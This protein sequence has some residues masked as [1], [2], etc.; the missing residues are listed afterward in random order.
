[1][2]GEL[3][4]LKWNNHKSTF[5]QVIKSLRNERESPFA[6]ATIACDGSFYP[7]HRLVLSS[8]SDYFSSIF[9]AT[10][11]KNPVIVLKDIDSRNFEYLL[12]YMY[13]G[14]VNVR[15]TEL[16]DLVGAAESLKI[17][18]LAVPDDEIL[19]PTNEVRNSVAKNKLPS[20]YAVSDV[21]CKKR[22]LSKNFPTFENNNNNTEKLDVLA[23]NDTSI[24]TEPVDD[25]SN[26]LSGDGKFFG[27]GSPFHFNNDE[28]EA[29]NAE[30]V[31]AKSEPFDVEDKP[32]N[33]DDP[34]G[35]KDEDNEGE[36]QSSILGFM[37]DVDS[38]KE[39]LQQE[40][41][42]Q[43]SSF[44]SSDVSS[45]SA[46]ES[47]VDT[48]PF[49]DMNSFI[50][51]CGSSHMFSQ[52]EK[53]QFEDHFN[54]GNDSDSL[55]PSPYHSLYLV[56]GGPKGRKNS[57]VPPVSTEPQTE[58]GTYCQP[59]TEIDSVASASNQSLDALMSLQEQF[60]VSR[61]LNTKGS[62]SSNEK[63]VSSHL[64]SSCRLKQALPR[65]INNNS[66]SRFNKLK[67]PQKKKL[68]LKRHMMTH[69]GEKP[70]KCPIC[71]YRSVAY[72]TIKRHYRIHTGEKPFACSVCDYRCS[73][74]ETS[75]IFVKTFIVLH[76]EDKSWSHTG[77]DSKFIFCE[78]KGQWLEIIEPGL[79][80][81][82]HQGS[83]AKMGIPTVN[84]NS[85]KD[86]AKYFCQFCSHS[87]MYKG[88]LARHIRI[89]T[90]VKPFKCK[91]CENQYSDQT[92]LKHHY[93]SQHNYSPKKLS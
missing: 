64:L 6:D 56:P 16:R 26:S 38:S 42:S 14:E 3:L 49:N 67:Y 34:L 76:S 30:H 78:N 12:D 36:F 58:D 82:S 29:I 66:R 57:P 89:H 17:K 59:L 81:E 84:K 37:T 2:D 65:H 27:Q 20:Q 85:N 9:D 5:L 43:L 22:K 83:V 80:Y 86:A 44:Q 11:C 33:M 7:V 51:L 50:T 93:K 72:H 61:P 91:L 18:G 62:S 39:S 46:P 74:S 8:C 52:G 32:S 23:S 41:E 69:T 48:Y 45:F 28:T 55:Q 21:E 47:N 60:G 75:V 54:S 13:V 53:N 1:M 87:T 10:T 73:S 71:D 68:T 24:K 63:M 70:F 4:S 35:Y 19:K 88:N 90:G 15:Q 92:M 31:K 25:D 40:D 77:S 79:V